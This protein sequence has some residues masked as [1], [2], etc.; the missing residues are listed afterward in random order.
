MRLVTSH[1]KRQADVAKVGGDEIVKCLNLVEIRGLTCCKLGG[2]GAN[3]SRGIASIFFKPA[4]PFAH[5]FPSGK[6][7]EL[8]GRQLR[9]LVLGRLLLGLIVVVILALP[10][11]TG[12]AI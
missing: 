3:V 11:R 9:L 7:R 12:P 2:L 8:Y 10:V 5:V 4:V 1:A 6:G